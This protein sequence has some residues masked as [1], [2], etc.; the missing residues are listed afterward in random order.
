MYESFTINEDNRI[1]ILIPPK[2]GNAFY[3]KSD[4]AV[5]HYK[6]AYHDNYIDSNEQFSYKWDD[7]KFAINWEVKNPILSDRDAK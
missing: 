4:E 7:P 1:S 2:F 5:Y 6:L 3:V